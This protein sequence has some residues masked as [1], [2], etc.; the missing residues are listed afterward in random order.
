MY[1]VAINHFYDR[2]FSMNNL[3]KLIGIFTRL[4]FAFVLA[5]ALLNVTS[6]EL[7]RNE[8][9]NEGNTGSS[10]PDDGNTQTPTTPTHYSD[11]PNFNTADYVIVNETGKPDSEYAELKDMIWLMYAEKENIG[12]W[13]ANYVKTNKIKTIMSNER[14]AYW[15]NPDLLDGIYFNAD[16][17]NEFLNYVKENSG[18]VSG[19]REGMW[20]LFTHET[21]HLV[22]WNI[23]WWNLTNG[24]RPDI[25]AAARMLTEYLAYFYTSDRYPGT[26][27]TADMKDAVETQSKYIVWS[28]DRDAYD[29]LCAKDPSLPPFIISSSWFISVYTDAAIGTGEVR[30]SA[31]TP[32]LYQA[33]REDVLKVARA[34]LAC[35]DPKMA[36]VTDEALWTVFEVLRRA[37]NGDNKYLQI[38]DDQNAPWGL[39]RGNL[40]N[41]QEFIAEW[42]AAFAAQ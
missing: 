32:P 9:W 14:G 20:S 27:I 37:A 5:L 16:D 10:N 19:N 15:I 24:M 30:R 28:T 31:M 29:D 35:R 13:M 12:D 23:G 11:Y 41:F 22:Q 36:G 17:E 42:D 4:L 25:C 40:D 18:N 26:V 3:K 2:N 7:D 33:G 39:Y 1:G 8:W 34:L 38:F 21:M 6:C